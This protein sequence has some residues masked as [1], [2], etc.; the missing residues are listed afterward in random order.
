MKEF[1]LGKYTRTYNLFN[2][3]ILLIMRLTVI[4]IMLGTMLVHASGYAQKVNISVKDANVENVFKEIKKQTGYY[5][6]YDAEVL[7]KSGK[8]NFTSNNLD[9]TE[10]LKQITAGTGL[11]YKII[12]K[13][14]II[15]EATKN[16]SNVD[17]TIKGI[18]TSKELNGQPDQP[19]PGAVVTVKGTKMAV[20]TDVNGNYSISAP[21]NGV[22]VFSLIGYASKEIAIEGRKNINITLIETASNLEAVIITAYGTKE[23]KENQVGSAFQITRKDLDMRP[24]YRLDQL[25]EGKVPGLQVEMQDATAGSARPRYQTRIRGEATWGSSNEPLWVVDGIKINTGDETNGIPGT[26]TSISTL[27]FLNPDDI[28]TVTVLKDATATSIYGADG[29]NGVVLIT[30]KKGAKNSKPA[31]NYSFRTGINLLNNSRFNMLTASEYR[32]LEAESFA[33]SSLTVNP[34]ADMGGDTDWYDVFFRNGITTN[35]N[36]SL[37]GGNAKTN[38]FIS[39]AYFNEKPIVIANETDRYS[40]RINVN[41]KVGKLINL[42]LNVGASRN[43][44][45]LFHPGNNYYLNRPIDSPYNPDGSFVY[46]FYNK[47]ADAT[48]NDD[49][50]KTNVLT[51]G[52][53]GDITIIPGLKYTTTNG[54]DY[55]GIRENRY[56]SVNVWVNRDGARAYRANTTNF[57]WNSQHRF[58]YDK[59]IKKHE[60]SALLGGEAESKGRKTYYRNGVGF[61]NDDIR[62]VDLAKTIQDDY[63]ET[64]QTGVS[65]YGQV[66]YGFDRRYNLV[67]SYRADANSNFGT[68]VQWATFSSIGAS[69]TISNEKFWKIKQIDFAKLKLSYGTNGNS[70]FGAYRSKG[71][72]SVTQAQS[73]NG[74]PGA[75]MTSGEN[76]IL[77]WETTYII[78]GGLSLGLFKRISIEIE[79]Y[80]N[81]TT[82]ILNDV[83]VSRTN[84]FTGILQNL[85]EV[86]NTGIE[87][88]LNTQNILGKNFQWT[89]SFNLAHNKNKILKLYNG[90]DKVLATT[91]RRVGEDLNTNYLIRWAGVDPRDG[92]PLWYDARGNITREFD[93]N[94]RVLAG[95]STPDF[96]GG[97]TN[98]FS[99]KSFSLSAL[100]VY[101]VGGYAF[102][103]LQRD[104]ESDG[105][106]LLSDNQS[107][108]Q[109]DRWREAGDLALSP[110]S[111][112]NENPNSGRNSTRF[113]HK[114]TSLRL[115]NISMSYN[116]PI[117]F[118]ERIKLK[119]SSVYLQADNVGF[120]TPYQTKD[121]Y[122]DYRNSFNPSPQPLVISFGLN[123]GI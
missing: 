68:D 77:S 10:A 49:V 110:K 31:L 97:M 30:T 74:A 114:K 59:Q 121:G 32:E 44:N 53:S 34:V 15:S 52:I 22:L 17:I 104:A 24:L 120:W 54:I 112:L 33:N 57:F 60:L 96:F 122:N 73:Y 5:F 35:H 48:Y 111:I 4:L 63:S 84:G 118:L 66:K 80:R 39:A 67:A 79:A 58:N 29:A 89:T 123:V 13:T 23:R 8:I 117:S 70:R 45:D 105:R 76:P 27:S 99:Y 98:V 37:S 92:A 20:N 86:R 88:T 69:W 25:L 51:G 90:D 109:L 91:I 75:I 83:D 78:N 12:D 26:Q 11:T 6:L 21:E 1:F 95:S 19:L 18:V 87:L 119:R 2:R 71:I 56:A 7:K 46:K 28:E 108:N 116:L 40:T 50:Q 43:I 103:S 42:Q 64:E 14:V 81:L 41:Q 107:R 16:L 9:L 101:N 47:L 93:L 3:K 36:I 82:N 38:Y 61:D 115:T 65:Y 102:S 106:N 85:G 72:Y 94:N 62:N 55:S 100:L 113:L